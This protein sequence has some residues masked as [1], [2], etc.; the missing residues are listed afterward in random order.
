MIQLIFKKIYKSEDWYR[1]SKKY[2]TREDSNCRKILNEGD[3]VTILRK[4]GYKLLI[5]NYMK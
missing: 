4:K 3:V 1:I 5:L 2:I